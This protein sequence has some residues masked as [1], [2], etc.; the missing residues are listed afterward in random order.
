MNSA[1]CGARARARVLFM[2][3]V[4]HP[5][6]QCAEHAL[7]FRSVIHNRSGLAAMQVSISRGFLRRGSPEFASGFAGVVVG[8]E[9]VI[10]FIAADFSRESKA[11]VGMKP[12]TRAMTAALAVAM[13]AVP[14]AHVGDESDAAKSGESEAAKF[15]D[16][17]KEL[18]NRKLDQN[19]LLTASVF[20]S[21][22]KIHSRRST[23]LRV[24]SVTV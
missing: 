15:G 21:F 20:N 1:W 2:A 5:A 22:Q 10:V 12:G 18:R 7:L 16:F 13:A 24:A 4:H 9:K 8:G 17:H 6:L 11:V 14:G 19:E 23:P 3:C